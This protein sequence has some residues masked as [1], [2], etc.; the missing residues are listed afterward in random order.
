MRRKLFKGFSTIPGAAQG[1]RSWKL[2]DIE[3]VKRDLLNHFHTHRGE[4]V[5]LPNFGCIIWDMLFQPLTES[6]KE[7]IVA[8]AKRIVNS[9]SRVQLHDIAVREIDQGLIINIVLYFKPWE[10]YE[11]FSVEFDR[12]TQEENP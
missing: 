5:M 2:N 9:D 4:R 8:E 3:L 6:N 1:R 12:R 10:V 11:N 7:I